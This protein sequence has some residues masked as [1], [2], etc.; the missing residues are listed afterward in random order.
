MTEPE[1]ISLRE[2]FEALRKADREAMAEQIAALERVHK[3]TRDA[4]DRAVNKAFESASKLS[5]L[6]ND[7]I[8]KMDKLNETFETKASVSETKEI[9]SARFTRIERWQA[10]FTGGL[11][12]ASFIGLLNLIQLFTGGG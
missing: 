11:I 9:V 10:R 6:H 2:H 5:D 8:R 7:L 3:L 12:F 1:H 4:D